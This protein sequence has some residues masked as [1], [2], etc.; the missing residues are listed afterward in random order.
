[1]GPLHVNNGDAMALIAGTGVGVRAA[2]A[3]GRLERVLPEWSL[4]STS[5]HWV[6]PPGGQRPRW[7]CSASYWRRRSH[8]RHGATVNH[9]ER[10]R[11]PLLP[12][13]VGY[14]R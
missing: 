3:D 9:I 7:R 11:F 13:K 5:V 10:G 2:L 12:I 14:V 1:V 4:P 8:R 6:T